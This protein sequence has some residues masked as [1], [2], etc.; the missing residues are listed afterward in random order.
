MSASEDRDLV[1]CKIFII[2]IIA[3]K[4]S[5]GKILQEQH[6]TS[7]GAPVLRICMIHLNYHVELCFI[8]SL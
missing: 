3:I 7:N 5:N 1:K 8:V 2:V 6:S 4:Q